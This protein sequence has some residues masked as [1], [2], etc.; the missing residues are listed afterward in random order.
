MFT[1]PLIVGPPGYTV[2]L[3]ACHHVNGLFISFVY[4]HYCCTVMRL[5]ICFILHLGVSYIRM[6]N[7]KNSIPLI[8]LEG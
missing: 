4:Q 5:H 1:T 8:Q 6:G 2:R 3:T 7:K